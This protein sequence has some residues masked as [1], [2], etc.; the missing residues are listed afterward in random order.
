M[1]DDRGK[2]AVPGLVFEQH[3][4]HNL[5]AVVG[6]N[7]CGNKPL[8]FKNCSLE[9]GVSKVK[10]K[11]FVHKPKLSVSASEMAASATIQ[12]REGF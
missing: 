2:N 3:L 5:I 11:G 7:P 4:F 8:A 9:Q 12:I 10:A 6:K 1:M